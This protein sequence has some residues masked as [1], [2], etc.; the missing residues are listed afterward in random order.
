MLHVLIAGKKIL[1]DI[2]VLKLFLI[3]LQ[4]MSFLVIIKC[5]L[6][7]L[8]AHIYQ[9]L[10]VS[11]AIKVALLAVM[12]VDVLLA[13]HIK[14][15]LMEHVLPYAQVAAFLVQIKHTAML[16]IKDSL[17]SKENA[18]AVVFLARA[19][20]QIISLSALLALLAYFSS[21]QFVF[22]V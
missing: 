4:L 21:I 20:I 15:L 3:V 17:L 13:S 9:E 14:A 6:V 7:A 19:A 22:P 12:Q 10:V 16:V 5:A 2:F 18:V 8:L 1:L 11:L